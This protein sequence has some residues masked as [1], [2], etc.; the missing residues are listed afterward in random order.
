MASADPIFRENDEL[1]NPDPVATVRALKRILITE[2]EGTGAAR[3][4]AA[5]AAAI[6]DLL[7][8][9]KNSTSNENEA[10]TDFRDRFVRKRRGLK[11]NYGFEVLGTI[12]ADEN[13]MV[14]FFIFRLDSKYFQLQRDIENKI[15]SAPKTLDEAVSMAKDRVEVT[16]KAHETAAPVSI[17]TTVARGT[18]TTNTGAKTLSPSEP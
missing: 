13:E 5:K 4:V 10:L 17:F 8:I 16:K 2:R 11:N 7:A 9:R 14:L 6:N 3:K 12:F 15:V 18:P 1:A